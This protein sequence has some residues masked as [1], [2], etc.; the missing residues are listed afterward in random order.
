[1]INNPPFAILF[2][3]F[4]DGLREPDPEF[5]REQRALENAQ[6]PFHVVNVA[7][8]TCGD[9]DRALWAVNPGVPIDVI[10]RGPILHPAE[11]RALDSELRSRGL[12]LLVSPTEY[13]T[14]LLFPNWYPA[15]RDHAI[16]AAW[17]HG[18]DPVEALRA[19]QALSPPPYFIKDFSK[20]AKEIAPR[21]CIVGGPDLELSMATSI[22][23]LKKY[24]GD[25]FEGGI[26][27]RPFTK[28]RRLA[29]NPFGGEIFEEYRL[30]FF[31]G[32]MIART[33]YDRITGDAT[34][35]RDFAFLAGKIRSRF[36][37]ADIAVT[38]D[39][40]QAIL[41]IGDGGSSALP[42]SLDAAEFYSKIASVMPGRQP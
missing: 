37:T 8:L 38:A 28:L 23:E 9:L 31:C 21:G 1:M 29:E 18:S 27:I 30:F 5:H 13:E 14:T 42:P 36:F 15:V 6:M 24:R 17:I 40:A 32:Q 20:S 4:S 10:Y 12:H 7:A 19:A 26:V 39:G 3:A 35:L 25:R 2:P 22:R 16:P 34:V 41:E 11:Y 33:G